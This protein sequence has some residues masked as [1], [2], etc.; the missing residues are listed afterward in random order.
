MADEDGFV[1]PPVVNAAGGQVGSGGTLGEQMPKFDPDSNE[2]VLYQERLEN[3]FNA[4]AI[5]D[6]NRKKALLQ[7]SIGAKPY[8]LL[9]D[10]CTPDLPNTKTYE[11]LCGILKSYYTPAV[12]TYKERKAFY[13]ISKSNCESVVEWMARIKNMASNCSFNA[14]IASVVLEKFVTGLSGRAFDRICEEDHITLTLERAL[15]LKTATC[16]SCSKVGHLASVYSDKKKKTLS[17]VSENDN[18]DF[19]KND[20]VEFNARE[21]W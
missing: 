21:N 3:L 6:A 18:H 16:H 15:E 17:Y 1:P 4:Y 7:N 10:L 2:W 11:Q 14:N 20:V 9:R 19:N 8:K 13:A 5:V 12:V